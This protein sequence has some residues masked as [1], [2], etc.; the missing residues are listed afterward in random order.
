MYSNSYY[1]QSLIKYELYREFFEKFLELMQIRPVGA[2][3][4]LADMHTCIHTYT[5]IHKYIHT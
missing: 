2:E 3:L 5:H 1:C 4:F